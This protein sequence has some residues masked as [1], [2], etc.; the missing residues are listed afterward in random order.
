MSTLERISEEM[1]KR[2]QLI[3]QLTER[4]LGRDITVSVGGDE[5]DLD[6]VDGM[7]R[8]LA[9]GELHDDF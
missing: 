5:G 6:D 8:D 3:R 4:K 7:V 9:F 2:R 1:H